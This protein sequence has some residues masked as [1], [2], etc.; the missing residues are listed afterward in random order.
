MK[1][2][3]DDCPVEEVASLRSPERGLKLSFIVGFLIYAS[4][5]PFAGAWI[6]IRKPH[7]KAQRLE[8]LRSP[9]RG[10]KSKMSLKIVDNICRS[11][12]RSVD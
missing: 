6:E 1:F 10:L 7:A 9:E 3:D 11:V 2:V 12:R 4:V 8:S 5:A